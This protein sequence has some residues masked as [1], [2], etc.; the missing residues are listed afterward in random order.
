MR[1]RAQACPRKLIAALDKNVYN[2]R[3]MTLQ[4]LAERIIKSKATQEWTVE[5]EFLED[6]QVWLLVPSHVQ[7]KTGQTFPHRGCMHRSCIECRCPISKKHVSDSFPRLHA[8]P[9][10]IHFLH[11]VQPGERLSCE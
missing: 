7:W 5:N 2:L 4:S 10:N 8:P 1:F 9:Y 3:F 11:D 6:G